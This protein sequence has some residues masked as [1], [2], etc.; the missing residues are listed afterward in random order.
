MAYFEPD[1]IN[2][3]KE[4]AANNH[5]D[6]FD[7]NRDRYLKV[8]KEPF[9][10]YVSDVIAAIRAEDPKLSIEPSEAI[11]RINRD[12]RFAKEKIP[13]K[14]HVS[15]IISK[16]GKKDKAYPGLYIQFDAEKARF[17]GGAYQLNPQQTAAMRYAIAENLT[18]FEKLLHAPA[19]KEAYGT[20]QGEKAKRIP[21]DLQAKAEEQP[22]LFNKSLYYFAELPP[23]TVLQ[24]NLLETT[25]HYYEV[26]RPVMQFLERK[27]FS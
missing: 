6:W 27:V 15:A 23:E 3:F 8:V 20:V 19:F 5:K 17:Y 13:Y 7:D 14:N 12:V 2:F 10:A 22:L 25:M 26:G 9:K 11:F 24:E 16:N 1:F 18:V 21:K 4:L